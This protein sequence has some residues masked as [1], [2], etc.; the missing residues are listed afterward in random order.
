[1]ELIRIEAY[2][3]EGNLLYLYVRNLGSTKVI[4][5]TVYLISPKGTVVVGPAEI[6]SS[7][8]I[9]GGDVWRV[10]T[11][12]LE[13]V[14]ESSGKVVYDAFTSPNPSIWDDSYVDYNNDW[15]NVYYDPNGLKLLSRSYGGWAVRGLITVDRVINLQE[16]PIVIEVDVQK[17]SYNVPNG[18][19]AGSPFAACLYLSSIRN[20]NPYFAKPW[21]AVKL[22]PKIFL[23][24]TEAQLV[25]RDEV[26]IVYWK[27][28]YE[29]H[30]APN[31]QPRGIFLLVFNET[32]KV[33][34]YFWANKRVGDPTSSGSWTA[35]GLQQVFDDGEVYIYLTIDNTVTTSSRKVHMRY[36]QVYKGTKIKVEG[37]MPGWTVQVTDINWNVIEV[38]GYRLEF[39][40]NGSSVEIEL[41]P[42]ILKNGMPILGHI[43]VITCDTSEY[44]ENG[45]WV[46]PPSE[47]RMITVSLKDVEYGRYKVKV[48]TR[49]GV[50]ASCIIVKS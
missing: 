5:T 41:L 40:S 50:E 47:T 17:T 2:K 45:G 23:V 44:S 49:N 13:C 37:L 14:R 28:L 38:D 29:W 19:A 39:L 33:Y 43:K 4:V 30:T 9:W 24:K 22:Y 27:T 15:S 10:D 26:G 32:N 48:V 46:V 8:E 42:Y 35:T 18:D 20:K 25:A 3:I 16:L 6:K 1:M 11:E 12:S 31:T 21:F 34:Y 36:L 7:T